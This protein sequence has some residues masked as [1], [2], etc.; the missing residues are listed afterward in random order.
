VDNAPSAGASR[1]HPATVR[2]IHSA[3]TRRIGALRARP[4]PA[5]P[6]RADHRR[7]GRRRDLRGADR[8]DLGRGR[9]SPSRTAPASTGSERWSRPA[10]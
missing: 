9:S 8:Q 1:T 3:G 5:R 10:R 4:H 2:T 7:I 6:A